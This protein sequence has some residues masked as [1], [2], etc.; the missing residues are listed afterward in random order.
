MLQPSGIN[1]FN[2]IVQNRRSIYPYQFEKE[3][4]IPDELIREILENA[5][6]APT[7]KLTQPWH[8]TVFSGKG[9]Q[10]FSE[11]QT[12][13]YT[14][15]AG[16]NFK[17]SKLKNLREYPLLS[18]HVIVVGMKR[19][20]EISIP[21]IEEVIAVSCAVENIFL[22]LSAC[23]LG[24]YLSTGGITYIE[25]AKPYFNLA[26]KDKLIGTFF[27]GYPQAIS[28]PLTKRAPLE[29]KMNWIKE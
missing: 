13:I 19:T 2:S 17:E 12:E 9:R 21:E 5:I 6:R 16:K 26:P 18:S 28:N 1:S 22:S 20:E 25:E 11:M 8:F 15:F 3:K 29:E 10:V 23:N 4:T 27:I 7:H 24:G 14:R